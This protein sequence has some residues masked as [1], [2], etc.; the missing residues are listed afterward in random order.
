MLEKHVMLVQYMYE[1]S[2]AT[3]RCAVGMS[4]FK[5]ELELHQ[6]STPNPFLFAMV[7]DRLTERSLR[8]LLYLVT[9][10]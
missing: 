8:R 2:L 7:M 5:V 10:S 4:D 3:M 1:D 6:E 9:T